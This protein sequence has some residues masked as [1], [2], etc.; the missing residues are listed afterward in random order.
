MRRFG[1]VLL[2]ATAFAGVVHAGGVDPAVA[3]EQAKAQI[4]D[5]N[6]SQAASVL[7]GAINATASMRNVTE[8]TQARTAL[9]F[10]SAVAYSALN[11]EDDALSH[12][13]EALRLSP[14][15]RGVDRSRYDAQFVTLF[16]RARNEVVGA[17]RF[18]ELYPGF[19]RAAAQLNTVVGMFDNPAVEYL[20]SRQEKRAWN[21]AV[22]P[23]ER[24]RVNEQ[25]WSV[26]DRNP[27]TA[28][29]EFRDTFTRRVAFADAAFALPAQRGAMT[30]RGR[31]FAVLGV[32]S[33]VRRRAF[34][35]GDR[36]VVMSR[37]SDG[38]EVGTVEY[39]FYTRDQLPIAYAK[40]TVVFRFVSHQGIGDFVLQRDGVAMN[41]LEASAKRTTRG[42]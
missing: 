10:Y 24:Q 6:Y 35:S 25:F 32:P 30:D 39:W 22:T 21:D 8:Q 28:E 18:D 4:A 42:Q 19:E 1:P 15:I 5:R 40:P 9:H 7:G 26:R 13:E 34:N 23:D 14:H 17:G 31:V 12:L 20:G 37:G 11:R 29:N 3:L 2:F 38:I 27:A 33:Y 36:I 16:E 41:V